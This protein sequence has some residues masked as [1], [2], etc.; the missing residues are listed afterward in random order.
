[1]RELPRS[2]WRQELDLFSREHEGSPARLEV[3]TA[4]G[5]RTEAHALPFNGA[6]VDAPHSSR[7]EISL[8]AKADDHLTHEIGD[9][10]SVSIDDSPKPGGRL[11]V[12]AADGTT[13][14]VDFEG[15]RP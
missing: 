2:E 7:I 5:T 12:R 6:T 3:R 14:R 8:G 11:E 1:M 10:V 13:A 9:A 4:G 15:R